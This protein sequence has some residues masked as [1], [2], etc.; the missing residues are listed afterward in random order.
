MAKNNSN[1][2][3]SCFLRDGSLDRLLKN[4]SIW[5]PV[6]S[7]RVQRKQSVAVLQPWE[8]FFFF[9]FKMMDNSTWQLVPPLW[10]Q[11]KR[12]PPLGLLTL[13]VIVQTQFCHF[14]HKNSTSSQLVEI[15]RCD[16]RNVFITIWL[17]IKE[18]RI[19]KAISQSPWN[20]ILFCKLINY[21]GN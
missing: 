6:S 1:G 9:F 16:L 4:T 13:K 10:V 17:L 18:Q 21:I 12:G 19:R 20:V 15:F 2:W 3:Y 8:V 7:S 11:Y 5:G 14:Y